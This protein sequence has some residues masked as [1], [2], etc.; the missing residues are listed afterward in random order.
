MSCDGCETALDVEILQRRQRRVLTWV[1][2][3]NLVAF[4]LMVVGSI[5][6][7]SASLLSGTLDNL[8]DALTYAV[9]LA[10]VGASLL[11][12]ARVAFLKGILIL[13][14]GVAVGVQIIW[15]ANHL[16]VPLAETMGWVAVANL[17][18]NGVCLWLLQPLKHDD[19]NMGSMW[20]CSK[21]DVF[22]GCA[23]LVTAV[24]VAMFDSPLPD[25]LVAGA[26]LVLFLRS[27]ARVLRAAWVELADQRLPE[28]AAT[29]VARATPQN[30]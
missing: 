26:L 8:G 6:S 11:V 22:E 1:L 21:N 15:R 25:L 20:E 10:V 14:A 12:K 23:V 17:A 18:A 5:V 13:G 4:G 3:I 24:A 19:I 30:P 28:T 16:E 7:G 29:P 9:S 27:A 2:I